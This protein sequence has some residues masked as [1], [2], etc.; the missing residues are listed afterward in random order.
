VSNTLTN[1]GGPY[2]GSLYQPGLPPGLYEE[3]VPVVRPVLVHLDTAAF[4]GLAQRGPV[5]TPVRVT[6]LPQFHTVFGDALD[7]LLLPQAVGAFFANGGRRCVVVRCM[8]MA[9]A[10]TAQMTLP[11]LKPDTVVVARN[12][13]AWG[14][15]LRLVTRLL[16]RT[17]PLRLS[18]AADKAWPVNTLLAP[19]HRAQPGTTLLLA[20]TGPLS[21]LTFHVSEVSAPIGGVTAVTLDNFLPAAFFDPVNGPLLLAGTMELLVRIDILLDDVPVETWDAA[22]LHPDHPDYLA[23]LIGRRAASEALLA[24]RLSGGDEPDLAWGTEDDPAGSE[25]LRPSLLLQNIVLL[26]TD[27]LIAAPD[28]VLFDAMTLVEPASGDDATF[29]TRRTD[30][31]AATPAAPGDALTGLLPFADRPGAI[32]AL[33]AWDDKHAADPIAMLAMP[34]LLHPDAPA[35]V[36]DTTVPEA[37]LCFGVGA[38]T[39]SQSTEAAL[40]YPNLGGGDYDDLQAAQAQLVATCDSIGRRVALLD[41]PPGLPS[42]EIMRWRQALASN[43]AA[44]FAPWLRAAP[45]DDPRGDALTLPPSATVAGLIARVEQQIGV[46]ASPGAQTI[47]GVFALAQDPGLPTPGFLHQ[48][49]IDAIRLTEK[50]IQLMGSRTTSLDPDWTHISVRRIMDWL[51]A[52]LPLDLA[53][54]PFEPN[55]PTLWRAMTQAA[56]RRLGGLYN[57]GA[58]AGATATQ[59]Y[60]V[61]C[62]NTTMTQSDLDNGR[63]IMLVGVAPAVPAEFL[64]FSLIHDGNGTPSVG[65]AP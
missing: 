65:V 9:N 40:P 21:S 16:R 46:F 58:L 7:G 41:L 4:I 44:L 31:F 59:S 64:V 6:S 53:W 49:R 15:Q 13:G 37:T 11:G 12:P 55:S 24:P 38:Q 23:R 5:N 48:E 61:R 25:F 14:N 18:T 27:D 32:D 62:D 3:R 26:P 8:D 19:A 29:T 1:P 45:V 56:T 39:V 10:R 28:G 51:M 47:N 42:G 30:F 36:T 52:Q 20:G 63:A 34:D 50:G 60:F 57:V 54:T 17:L 35:A 22:A 43:R 2:T 33:A